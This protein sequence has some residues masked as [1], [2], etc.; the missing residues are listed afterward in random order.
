VKFDLAKIVEALTRCRRAAQQRRHRPLMKKNKVTVFDGQAKLAGKGKVSVEKDG[1]KTE[2]SAKHIII[3]TGRAG[4]DA[5]G[6]GAGRQAGVD[7]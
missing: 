1:K 7:L 4:A 6:A 2:L 3:A 5:A